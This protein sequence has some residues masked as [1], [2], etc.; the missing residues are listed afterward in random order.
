MR[1]TYTLFSST[2]YTEHHQ[3]ASSMLYGITHN[4]W[5]TYRKGSRL[6][7]KLSRP[8]QSV[9]VCY[10]SWKALRVLTTMASMP[11]SN[12]HRVRTRCRLIGFCTN[13]KRRVNVRGTRNESLLGWERRV[14]GSRLR[15]F[16]VLTKCNT[17]YMWP[18]SRRRGHAYPIS[19][20]GRDTRAIHSRFLTSSAD[21]HCTGKQTQSSKLLA[22]G[23]KE[24]I[25]Q[26]PANYGL[27]PT[28]W[29]DRDYSET[30]IK[31]SDEYCTF[32]L[33]ASGGKRLDAFLPLSRA[34]WFRRT[35]MAAR[36]M[37]SDLFCRTL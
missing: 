5:A 11:R 9:K 1:A 14:V 23:A 2:S 37:N 26:L 33:Q 32:L 17:V 25:F 10:T 30:P 8:T 20:E 29:R 34:L 31:M 22:A 21:A 3:P 18:Q 4:T 15:C 16:S 6:R 7:D 28:A 13:P 12:V 24:D 27:S 19:C 36:N 35:H